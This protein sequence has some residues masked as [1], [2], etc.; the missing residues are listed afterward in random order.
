VVLPFGETLAYLIYHHTRR[1]VL[2]QPTEQLSFAD[3]G[4]DPS[5]DRSK[6]AGSKILTKSIAITALSALAPS[7]SSTVAGAP[8]GY[9]QGLA[10]SAGTADNLDQRKEDSKEI[11]FT[12]PVCQLVRWRTTIA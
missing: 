10:S 6:L 4:I 9:Q 2:L 7:P 5:Q 1:A 12:S 8:L 3:G 11:V